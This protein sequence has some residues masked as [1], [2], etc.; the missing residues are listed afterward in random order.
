MTIAR[1]VGQLLWVGFEGTQVP[2]S[3]RTRLGAGEAGAA[4]LFARNLGTLD[5]IAGLCDAL[6]DAAPA[7]APLLIA[8]DQEGGRVQR[9]REPATVFPPMLRL[10]ELASRSPADAARAEQLAGEVGLVLGRELAALGFDLD[11]APV[12]D[13]HTNP[14]NPVIGDRAFATDAALVT[15]LA[16]ALARGLAEAGVISCG[17]HFP[18]HGDTTEDSH[19]ALPRVDHAPARLHAVELAPFR[20]LANVLPTIMTAHVIF[21]ALDGTVPATL[22]ER[23]IT[24]LLRGE[25]GYSGVVV[26]DD[27]EMKA[28]ADHYG[29]DEALE[30][31]LLAGCDAFLLCRVEELQVRAFEALVRAAEARS[32]VRVRVA[33]SAARVAALK[34]AHQ[35]RSASRPPRNVVGSSAHR[36][37]AAEL[38]RV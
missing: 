36:A 28:I 15:R 13:I 2:P 4:V 24:G 1:E 21:P 5:E 29:L 17:K 8:V 11:F 26:S 7:D 25:L 31:G 6:H 19:L 18:G 9:V 35:R 27:L 12:L 20:A 10:G 33:E 3:L 30:R 22:S 37:L 23:V 34:L 16:G 14:A 38:A 32:A